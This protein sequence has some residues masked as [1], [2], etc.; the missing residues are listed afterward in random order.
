MT[1]DQYSA[2]LDHTGYNPDDMS[3]EFALRVLEARDSN[4]ADRRSL[5]TFLAG[6]KAAEG[7]RRDAGIDRSLLAGIFKR[8]S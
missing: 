8:P 1:F 5:E 3:F 6:W 7:F 2:W 4:Y